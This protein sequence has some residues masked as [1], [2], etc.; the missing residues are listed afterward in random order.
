MNVALKA[1]L[2]ALTSLWLSWERKC[3]F[4]F[5]SAQ[6]NPAVARGT[7]RAGFFLLFV[8]LAGFY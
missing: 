3:W 6:Q 5:Q 8:L 7:R 2:L 1:E 4:G